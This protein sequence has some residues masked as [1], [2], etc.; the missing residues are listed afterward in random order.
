VQGSDLKIRLPTVLR[1]WVAEE[2][3]RDRRSMNA[4]IVDAVAQFKSTRTE[5]LA[6]DNHAAAIEL[7]ISVARLPNGTAIMLQ[8]EHDHLRAD[9]LVREP[10]QADYSIL[11]HVDGEKVVF[12]GDFV[13]PVVE[14][15]A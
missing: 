10:S 14:S 6:E 5:R 3:L 15:G 13:T 7:A 2:G 1:Q 11:A 8:T 9:I 12:A 4:I